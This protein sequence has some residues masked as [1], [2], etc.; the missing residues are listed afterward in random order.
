[1]LSFGCGNINYVT[2][3]KFFNLKFPE[4]LVPCYERSFDKRVKEM[5]FKLHS[6]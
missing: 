3:S 1:M 6:I 4:D 5:E 2:L